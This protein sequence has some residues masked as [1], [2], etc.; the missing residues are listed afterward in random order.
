MKL[1]KSSLI[2]IIL[3]ILAILL[4]FS[5]F[6][7]NFIRPFTQIFLMGSS[8]GKDILF[9]GIFGLFLLLNEIL[10]N[11]KSKENSKLNKIHENN[12]S[13]ENLIKS[14]FIDFK[15]I[16]KF[17]KIFQ[18][19]SKTYLKFSIILFFTVGIIGLILEISMRN[20]LGIN[21]FTTFVAMD[22]QVTSTSLLHSHIYKSVV[23]SFTS[24]IQWTIPSGIY[25]GDSLSKYTPKIANFI[26]IMLPI[27]FLSSLLSLK[28][29]LSSSRLI[30]IFAATC[31]LIGLV[32][33]GFFSVPFIIGIYGM[34]F[35]YF[36]EA[37]M[38]YYL[39]KI[40]KN[41]YIVD[42]SKDAI[43]ILKTS[44]T[45]PK[46][47]VIRI[48]PHVFLSLIIIFGLG[49]A[50]IGTNVE[51]YDVEIMNSHESIDLENSYSIL[52]MEKSINQT[53]F[54]ISSSYHE[55]KLLNNLTKSLENKT[56]SFSMTWNFFSYF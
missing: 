11:N 50:I 54:H 17:S 39:G 41:K 23:G 37:R 27:L 22:P 35:I 4:F 36:D 33:G 25:T 43:A 53:T 26:I 7:D 15:I 42:K 9:F 48:L 2:G 3:I 55:I 29:R 24:F 16:K 34:V 10:E 12:E 51:Y 1:S 56:S 31:S 20:Y 8:K 49:L 19:K 52:S 46:T 44:E 28:N 32:D 30:L 40:F 21:P 45:K 6:L 14:I 38:N 5:T 13:S 18:L 47:T